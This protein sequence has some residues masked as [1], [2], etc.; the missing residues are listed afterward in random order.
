MLTVILTYLFIPLTF[1]CGDD[2]TSLQM[3]VFPSYET[4]LGTSI[5]IEEN[6]PFRIVILS[7]MLSSFSGKIGQ[8][9]NNPP[10]LLILFLPW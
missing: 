8:T 3:T 2:T 9:C 6:Q 10:K 1:S 4:T 7:K 5:C